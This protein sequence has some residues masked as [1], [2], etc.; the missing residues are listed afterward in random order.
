MA[1]PNPGSVISEEHAL[2]SEATRDMV[3]PGGREAVGP[4]IISAA[5]VGKHNNS[6]GSFWAVV[7]GFVV[8]ATDFVA[9][10]PG[11]LHKLLATDS[12]A[13][14]A[15]GQ[16]FGFSFARGRN[17][18]FPATAERFRDGVARYLSGPSAGDGGGYLLPADVAF[19]PH[20]KVVILGRL[21][22]A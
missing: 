16:P 5:E 2:E 10:H 11:G 22:G 13:A 3:P 15:T 4:R 21:E 14:G 1:D 17:A 19:P 12:P 7:D 8:D 9:N 20:G 18:H 6:D